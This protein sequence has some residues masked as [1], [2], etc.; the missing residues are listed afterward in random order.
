M[1]QASIELSADDVNK[2]KWVISKQDR[3]E[4]LRFTQ[5]IMGPVVKSTDRLLEVKQVF[6]GGSA[7]SQDGRTR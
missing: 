3:D 4:A 2:L 6:D 7:D 5:E 1:R